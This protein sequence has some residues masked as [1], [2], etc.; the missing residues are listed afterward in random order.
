MIIGQSKD[1]LKPC[2]MKINVSQRVYLSIAMLMYWSVV[3]PTPVYLHEPDY[4][5]LLEN[6]VGK[7]EAIVRKLCG[8]QLT[9]ADI[10]S[11]YK[12]MFTDYM[13]L[14]Y[15]LLLPYYISL[16]RNGI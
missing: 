8:L 1:V 3:I 7:R 9:R 13:A 14:C 16:F 6:L 15:F 11:M 4:N 10:I 5:S 2:V 12:G